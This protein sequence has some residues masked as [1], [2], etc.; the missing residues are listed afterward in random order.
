MRREII[1]D[2]A[3][4]PVSIDAQRVDHDRPR[5]R[6]DAV[7][8]RADPDEIRDGD[9]RDLCGANRRRSCAQ[10]RS[11]RRQTRIGIST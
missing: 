1:G 11:Y 6:H 7:V 5:V 9:R 4:A 3:P 2:A 10:L 8:H